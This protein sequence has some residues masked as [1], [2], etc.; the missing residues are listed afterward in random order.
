MQR[1]GRCSEET[2][3][4]GSVKVN[5]KLAAVAAV[6][7]GATALTLGTAAGHAGAQERSGMIA[8]LRSSAGI[9]TAD[10]ALFVVRADGTGL[11]RL[12]PRSSRVWD[13]AWSPDG[14]VIAYADR[15]TAR[16]AV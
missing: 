14:S 1:L 2:G 15:G 10:T 5:S 9:G 16:T 8:F 13:H 3:G 7:L 12:T 4:R 6:G 11:R